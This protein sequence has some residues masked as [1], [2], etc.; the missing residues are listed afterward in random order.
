MLHSKLI[1]LMV[2]IWSISRFLL[3]GLWKSRYTTKV[4][5][6]LRTMISI[7]GCLYIWVL[8]SMHISTIH[9]LFRLVQKKIKHSVVSCFQISKNVE[10]LFDV[11]TID[12]RRIN[13]TCIILLIKMKR[14]MMSM[15]ILIIY[16]ITNNIIYSYFK[17]LNYTF[18]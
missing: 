12:R 6:I 4:Y 11:V 5:L 17:W 3:K 13:W 9:I 16:Y 10:K 7:L 18:Y 2:L 14:R 8:E 1:I 15:M